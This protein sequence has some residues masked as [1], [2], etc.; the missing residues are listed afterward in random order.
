MVTLC[1]GRRVPSLIHAE[2]MADHTVVLTVTGVVAY[3]SPD[4]MTGA[5]RAAIVRW[6][7]RAILLDL[8]DVS[9]L[10][11]AGVTALLE[12]HRMAAWAG[13]PV[14]LINVG[15]FLMGQLR[16][17]GLSAFIR[18]HRPVETA[19]QAVDHLDVGVLPPPTAQ[20]PSRDSWVSHTRF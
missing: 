16:E 14:T 9:V 15:T 20:T 6:A 18:T 10:D 13:I 5:V 7:P 2:L 17:T 1:H 11:A 8:A 3:Q 19:E 4:Q 12:S